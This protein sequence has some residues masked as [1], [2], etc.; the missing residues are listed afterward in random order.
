MGL[1]VDSIKGT[2]EFVRNY[3][4]SFIYSLI[5]YLIIF[6]V[7]LAITLS[8]P[9][10]A[11][12]LIGGLILIAV[13][14][15]FLGGGFSILVTQALKENE[16]KL[17]K[18]FSECFNRIIEILIVTIIIKLIIVLPYFLVTILMVLVF[19]PLAIALVPGEATLLAAF[20]PSATG[21]FYLIRVVEATLLLVFLA[22]IL[23]A[24]L[25]VLLIYLTTRLWL[26]LPIL[27]IERK[28][29][30][31]SIKESW[32]V[33]EGKVLSILATYALAFLI[34]GLPLVL[35]SQVIRFV[36]PIIE[37][38]WDAIISIVGGTFFGALITIY[39]YNLKRSIR[40]VK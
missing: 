35:I 31:E 25:S 33:T 5:C 11:L 27:M 32:K 24:P 18:T 17:L 10:L 30:I 29:V 9:L 19:R 15:A 16:I 34:M 8:M 2:F 7:F 38:F 4:K 3:P 21:P 12:S 28:S 6:G 20:S 23:T 36:V 22:V 40:G 13:G 26:A 1:A 14:S 39:Y 37:H